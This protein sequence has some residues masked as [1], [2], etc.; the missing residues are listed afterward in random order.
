MQQC[1]LLVD[2]AVDDEELMV[3]VRLCLH[4]S[5]GLI[6]LHLESH[7]GLRNVSNV[8]YDWSSCQ[9]TSRARGSVTGWLR[10]KWR[11]MKWSY[12]IREVYSLQTL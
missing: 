11:G 5:P 4:H 9:P 7:A 1:Q 10:M 3:A 12:N 2:A 8:G 6:R